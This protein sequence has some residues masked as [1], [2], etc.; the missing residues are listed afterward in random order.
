MKPETHRYV[1]DAPG[2]YRIRI[3]GRLPMHGDGGF[4]CMTDCRTRVR[5][6]SPTTTL[7]GTVPDQAGLICVLTE[8]YDMGYPLLDVKRLPS[9]QPESRRPIDKET[10]TGDDSQRTAPIPLPYGK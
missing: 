9:G 4:A 3:C 2:I 6:E 5:G 1:F 10:E 7:T 8:L